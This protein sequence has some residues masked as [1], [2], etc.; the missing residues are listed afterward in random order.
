MGIPGIDFNLISPFTVVHISYILKEFSYEI[1]PNWKIKINHHVLKS[2][3]NFT[4][5]NFA[6]TI[7]IFMLDYFTSGAFF[8][9]LG[10]TVPLKTPNLPD[11]RFPG[12]VLFLGQVAKR[13]A[14]FKY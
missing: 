8:D 12:I 10:Y 6:F 5:R 1:L 9:L 7:P 11:T 4:K 2:E 14:S 13:N 3:S